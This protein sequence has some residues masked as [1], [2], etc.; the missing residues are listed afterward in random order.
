VCVQAYDQTRMVAQA[1]DQNGYSG[2]AIRD[3]L[4]GLKGFTSVN[5]GTVD[6]GD[7]HQAR[8]AVGLYRIQ[9]NAIVKIQPG[10]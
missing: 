8:P 3:G 1:I 7:D 2:Q 10:G 4:A 5:G 6:M 9:N